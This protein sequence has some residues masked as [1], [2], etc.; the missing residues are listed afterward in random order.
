MEVLYMKV[1]ALLGSPRNN[2][3]TSLLLDEYLRGI[4]DFDKD[5]EVTKVFLQ[6]KNIQGCSSCEACRHVT[7]IGQCAIKDDMQELYPLFC[8]ADVVIYA[9]PIYWWSV[10]AQL[11]AFMD[12]C[13]ALGPIKDSFA[14]K[15]AALLMTYGGELP[16]KGPE[17]VKTMFEEI[18]DYKNM[19]LVDVCGVCTDD[20]MPVIENAEALRNV[21]EM[22]LTITSA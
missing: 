4:E 16:N 6:E 20:Y 7:T 15:K 21:Y 14:G 5:A 11:K 13:Y 10:S 17:L 8:N 18:C 9:T 2:G 3:N 22:G 1:L 12:R 19:D